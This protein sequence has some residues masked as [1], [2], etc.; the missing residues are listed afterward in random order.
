MLFIHLFLFYEQN[1]VKEHGFLD[2][3]DLQ[4]IFQVLVSNRSIYFTCTL[5]SSCGSGDHPNTAPNCDI[6]GHVGY[7]ARREVY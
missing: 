6:V 3:A 2:M 4:L 1:K 5:L 7:M